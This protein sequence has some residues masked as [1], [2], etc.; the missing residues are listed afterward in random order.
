MWFDVAVT[1]CHQQVAPQPLRT[2]L[3]CPV[4][5]DLVK[6]PVSLVCGHSFCRSCLA[7]LW[8]RPEAHSCP[9][10]RQVC[11]GGELRAGRPMDNL[12]EKAQNLSLDPKRGEREHRCDDHRE[13]LK[14]TKVHKERTL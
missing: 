13:E 4:C 10:C 8:E 9:E 12:A 6:G 5:P 2:G 3:T 11:P 7:G 1:L 14:S